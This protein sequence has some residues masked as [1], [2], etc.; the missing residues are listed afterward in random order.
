MACGRN[1]GLGR[2][3]GAYGSRNAAVS[4]AVRAALEALPDACVVRLL[5]AVVDDRP[6]APGERAVV[7]ESRDAV[8]SRG[9][10]LTDAERDVGEWAVGDAVVGPGAVAAETRLP[11]E[12]RGCADVADVDGLVPVSDMISSHSSSCGFLAFLRQGSGVV[13]F[14]PQEVVVHGDE[15]SMEGQEGA[16]RGIG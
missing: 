10:V 3:G 11:I 5:Q 12:E 4:G 8:F 7:E 1:R 16:L 9:Q 14:G 2:E 6:S 15:V 13:A